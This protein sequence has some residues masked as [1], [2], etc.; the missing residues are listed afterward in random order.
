MDNQE[1]LRRLNEWAAGPFALPSI[2]VGTANVIAAI[3]EMPA[4]ERA[5]TVEA[6]SEF[7]CV[8]CGSDDPQCQCWNDC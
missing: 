8:H 2:S 7:F 3:L 5:A 1:I 6:C 4:A